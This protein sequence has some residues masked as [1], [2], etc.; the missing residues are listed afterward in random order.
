MNSLRSV[1]W[2]QVGHSVSVGSVI[3]CWTS[4]VV[5]QFEQAYSYVGTVNLHALTALAL[6]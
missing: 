4:W 3:F 6:K 1:L 5:S 2:W